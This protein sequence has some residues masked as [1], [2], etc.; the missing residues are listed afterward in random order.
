[1]KL[2]NLLSFASITLALV[3]VP[4]CKKQEDIS[5]RTPSGS[6]AS[7]SGASASSPAPATD[8]DAQGDHITV[9]AHHKDP[10]PTDPV[11]IT[12]QTFRVVKADFDPQKIEGGTATIEID[13][14]SFRTDSDERD[15][16]LKSPAYLDVGKLATATI[17]IDNVKQ[18]TADTYT[19]EA[20]VTAHGVTKKLPVAFDVVER[21]TDKIRIKGTQ[22]FARLDFGIGSDPA[23][24]PDEQVGTDVT[25]EMSLT[26]AKT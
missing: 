12:F 17:K 3:A 19:A 26:I 20:T 15:E 6:S 8:T 21:K 24:N 14:S 7:G 11:R 1:M 22:T 25:I 23:S 16:H 9:L 13:L 5:G 2:L 10:K 18:K 4:A